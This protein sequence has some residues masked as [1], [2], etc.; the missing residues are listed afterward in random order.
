MDPF[1]DLSAGWYVIVSQVKMYT[2]TTAVFLFLVLLFLI[3]SSSSYSPHRL[4]VT[5]S[6]TLNSNL[7]Q[8]LKIPGFMPLFQKASSQFDFA[9][10]LVELKIIKMPHYLGSFKCLEAETKI[11]CHG[12]TSLIIIKISC[13]HHI[14]STQ[15]PNRLLG[16]EKS[17]ANIL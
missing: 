2:Y 8:I 15:S 17:R 10:Y 11:H 3:V 4:N 1:L 14:W 13:S 16:T 12:W 7:N 5:K 6:F 9:Q